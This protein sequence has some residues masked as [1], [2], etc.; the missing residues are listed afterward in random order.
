MRLL[1]AL[2][3]LASLAAAAAPAP[4]RYEAQLCVGTA[5]GS[6][7]SCGAAEAELRRGGRIDV[8]V[9]DIVYRLVASDL[10]LKVAM[11]H[12]RM[13]I[14]AFDAPYA[15]DGDVLRFSDAAKSVRYEV[16]LAARRR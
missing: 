6:A 14:D 9:A 5:P 8:R 4:G 16:R 7:P 12:G 3:G 11:L 10:R 2:L 13:Q 1:P 15:W